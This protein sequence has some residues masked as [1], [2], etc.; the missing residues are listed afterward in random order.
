MVTIHDRR[1]LARNWGSLTQ[2]ELSHPRRDGTQQ[3]LTREVYDHGSAASVLLHDPQADRVVLIRQFRLPAHLNGDSGHLIEACA[4]LLEGDDPQTCA[5]REA[6]EET[7]YRPHTLTFLFDL[8]MSPGSL[9]EKCAC[10]IGHYSPGDRVGQGG[11]LV[12]EGEDIEVLEMD[13]ETAY[14]MIGRGEI[15]DAKT[16]L[17]LQWL[18][19]SRLEAQTGSVSARS[20]VRGT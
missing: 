17:M 11:G 16:V 4:G 6:E 18:R 3:T 14:A 19:L 5:R 9:T 8:Y 13:F 10:F 12:H 20:S 15:V 2:F 1:T 7:G